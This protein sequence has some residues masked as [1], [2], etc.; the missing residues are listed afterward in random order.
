MARV[1]A[2][3]G[4]DVTIITTKGNAAIFQKSIDHDFNRGRSIKTHVLEF[5]AKQVG[6]PVG[7]ETF[8]ADTPLD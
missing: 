4:V 6:L 3:N 8:N 5:P 7:V 2:M 1:F